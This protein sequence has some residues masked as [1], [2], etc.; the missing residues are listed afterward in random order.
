MTIK[1]QKKTE[2]ENANWLHFVFHCVS[3]APNDCTSH[4]E[5]KKKTFD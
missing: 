5:V 3:H 4:Y 1:L 2:G